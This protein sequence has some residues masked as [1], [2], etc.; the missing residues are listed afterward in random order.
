MNIKIFICD[1][2]QK[3][4]L[5]MSKHDLLQIKSYIRS[6]VEYSCSTHYKLSKVWQNEQSSIFLWLFLSDRVNFS[7]SLRRIK[8]ASNSP[9]V[10]SM[11]KRRNKWHI[12][13]TY[14]ELFMYNLCLRF[15][16]N[17]INGTAICFALLFFF[18]FL[19]L[20]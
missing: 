10:L 1:E 12:A 16:S 19:P 2:M 18:C 3:S 4:N 20:W 15:Q 6:G 8:L 17:R 7:S 13:N 14:D 5:N 9:L 11:E